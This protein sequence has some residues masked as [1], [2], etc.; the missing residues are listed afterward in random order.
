MELTA[1]VKVLAAIWLPPARQ[2][3]RINHLTFPLIP[4]RKL[5]SRHQIQRRPVRLAS[6]LPPP[7]ILPS[8]QH[9]LHLAGR[10]QIKLQKVSLDINLQ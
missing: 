1:Y 6:A 7:S 8:T 4:D 3:G 2:D 9:N 5:P 10:H